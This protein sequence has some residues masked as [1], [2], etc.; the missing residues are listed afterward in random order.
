MPDTPVFAITYPCEGSSIT[1]QDFYDFATTVEAAVVGVDALATEA[2]LPPNVSVQLSL[3]GVAL[4]VATDI[5]YVSEDWDSAAIAAPPATALTVPADGMYF[6]PFY[7]GVSGFATLTSM[8]AAISVNG[9]NQYAFKFA[10]N[11][12]TPNRSV[13]HGLLRLAAG[14]LVRCNFLWTGTGGPG[15][16]TGSMGLIL[17]SRQF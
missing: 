5:T 14:D 8:R 9:V 1:M 2:V 3:A 17:H 7:A 16:V 15:T 6:V 13:P 11:S 12:G 4:N 10:P